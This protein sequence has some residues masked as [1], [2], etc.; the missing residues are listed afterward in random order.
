MNPVLT[1][2]FWVRPIILSQPAVFFR[3]TLATYSQHLGRLPNSLAELRKFPAF[4]RSLAI[5]ILACKMSRNALFFAGK[6]AMGM[7]YL[8]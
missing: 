5:L 8:E 4:L 1:E 3:A 7:A 6:A 2:G